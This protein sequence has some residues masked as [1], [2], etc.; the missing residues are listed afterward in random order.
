MINNNLKVEDW[1]VKS[2]EIVS[3][4]CTNLCVSSIKKK[5]MCQYPFSI[6]MF[7]QKSEI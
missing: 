6:M 1:K 3:L 2:T 4:W 5:S 7:E